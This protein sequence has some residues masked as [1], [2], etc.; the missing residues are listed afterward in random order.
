M[1]RSIPSAACRRPASGR[2]RIHRVSTVLNLEGLDAEN[3]MR[4][5]AAFLGGNVRGRARPLVSDAR[6][7]RR[8]AAVRAGGGG[9]GARR[10]AQAVARR[11]DQPDVPRPQA[12]PGRH[13]RHA[14]A[15]EARQERC[16]RGFEFPDGPHLPRHRHGAR[17]RSARH[18]ARQAEAFR[19]LERGQFMALGPALSR[20]PL[21]LRIGPTDTSPRN[22]TPR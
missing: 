12:R 9:R 7:G 8:G 6:G 1:P 15:G 2:A 5:A 19:D 18:G 10:G 14:A 21:G 13:H 20:R 16:R 3:Q 17:R 4:R 22:A 11:D